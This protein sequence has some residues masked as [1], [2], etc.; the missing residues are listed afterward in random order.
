MPIIPPRLDDRNFEDL[1]EELL[2]RIPAHT[3]EWVPQAGDPGRTMLELFAWLGETILYRANLVP[4]K[5]R[6]AFLSLLGQPLR[7]ATAAKGVISVMLNEADATDVVRLAASATLTGAARFETLQELAVLPITAECY[8]K[9]QLTQQERHDM[10]DVLAGLRK[11]HE[12]EGEL[13]GYVTTP[14]FN[15]GALDRQGVELIQGTTDNSL[16]LALLAPTA[17]LVGAIKQSLAGVDDGRA[18][19][20][21]IGMTPGMALSDPLAEHSQPG[22]IA[23]IWEIST[24]QLSNDQPL[25]SPLSRIADT[26]H[27]LTRQGIQR[28]VFPGDPNDFGVL[29]GDVR[30]DS[31]AGVGDRP[32]RL[33]DPEKLA[34]VVAW[35]RLRPLKPVQ[36]LKLSWVNINAVEIDQRQTFTAQVIGQSSGAGGQVF[37]LPAQQVDAHSLLLQVEASGRGYVEWHNVSDLSLLGRDDEGFVLDSEAGMVS[38]GDGVNGRIPE[39]GMRVRVDR[40]RA[41]GG[42]LGNLPA[43]SLSAISAKDHQGNALNRGLSVLQGV[44]TSGGEDAEDLAM[45]EKRIPSWLQHRN[46]SVTANDYRGLAME[47]SGVDLARVDILPRFMPQQRRT[48]VPGVV[49]VMVWPQKELQQAPNPRVDQPLIEKVFAQLDERRPL[50]T[51][52]YVIGCEYVALSLGVG[53]HIRQGFAHDQVVNAV[54]DAL[55]L[56]LWSLPPGGPFSDGWPLGRAVGDRELEVVVARVAGVNAVEAINLFVQDNGNWSKVERPQACEPVN[57]V[58][59]AWQLP[60]LFSIIV[61]SDGQTPDSL[62]STPGPDTG[63]GIAVPVVPEVC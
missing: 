29:E 46:R 9:R 1:V 48:D 44:A 6:L 49:S 27:D 61:A 35:L 57:V 53:I 2:A 63:S 40:M 33:D 56:Y 10:R 50:S 62:L 54:R 39:V 47:T 58:L 42:R 19:V 15:Q 24:P 30:I 55:K 13:D 28:F 31:N 5:Q 26:T 23:H 16:W 37:K 45:A 36:S 52:L 18:A 60:E 17:G 41:G 22:R 34:R 38:F 12:V 32:P 20:L 14:A 11:F 3:P 25:Y 7:A 8:Y 51:E 59:Q 21:S 4:E 43:A